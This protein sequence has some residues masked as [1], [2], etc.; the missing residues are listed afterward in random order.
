MRDCISTEMW[1]CL[2]V[3]WLRTRELEIENIWKVSPESFYVQVAREIDTFTGVADSTMYRDEG[4]CF[5]R[6]GRFLERSQ[7]LIA[8]LLAHIAV[9][10]IQ[11]G[12]TDTE[13]TS[14]LRACQ[15]FD[16]YKRSYSIDIQ[17]R[18]VLD[19]LVTDSMLP[20]SLCRALDTVATELA[21]IGP[22][23]GPYVVAERL[24]GR[25][26]ALVR[27]EWPD[28]EDKAT[29]IEQAQEHCRKLH[30]LVVASYFDYS[31]EDTLVR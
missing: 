20:G 22:G 15:A 12:T 27:Y 10:R 4:W 21:A 23:P 3:A 17:S 1:S 26:C 30:E 16:A 19:L 6:L 29:L 13:W 7:L 11:G 31:I 18:R 8:L 2:N 9:G 5:M 25:I 28:R 24:A 14:L